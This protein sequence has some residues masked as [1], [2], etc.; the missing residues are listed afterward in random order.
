MLEGVEC[1]ESPRFNRM[2]VP[3]QADNLSDVGLWLGA[4]PG[5]VCAFGPEFRPVPLTLQV[6]GGGKKFHNQYVF[7]KGVLCRVAAFVLVQKKE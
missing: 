2:V 7:D 4:P 6:Q 1:A 3:W 5:N